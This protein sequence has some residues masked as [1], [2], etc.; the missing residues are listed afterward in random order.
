MSL[1]RFPGFIDV[2]VHLRE[3]G[4]TNK[5]DFTSGSRAAVKGG[6]TYVL[7][8]PNNPGAPTI[9]PERLEEKIRLAGQKAICDVGFHYGTDGHNVNTF[10]TVWQNPYVYGLKAYCDHTTGELLIEDEMQLEH[11]F[12]AW[13]SEK[14]ILVHGQG[15]TLSTCIELAQTFARRL[16]VCH[17]ATKEDVEV[18][19]EAKKKKQLVTAGITLHHLFLS[20]ADVKRLGN[21]AL[22]KPEIGGKEDQNILWEA[23]QDGTIDLVESDHAPHTKKEKKRT[24]PPFGVPG[25]ET[26]LGLLWKAVHEGKLEQA[27]IIRLLY[28]NPKKIFNIPDQ[29]ATYI[30]L[31]PKK[32]YVVGHDGYETKCGWSPF[33]GWELYGKAETVVLRGKTLVQAGRLV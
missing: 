1:T 5:E 8:M 2:H 24:S 7:D 29:P 3:P 31:D 28:D 20:P 6:F 21:F 10:P 33:D 25:L 13:N 23:L 18:I 12:K 17:V 16:H 27:D 32:P 15:E 22:V 26:T 30:A 14:P 9:T 19:R 4:A 11:V